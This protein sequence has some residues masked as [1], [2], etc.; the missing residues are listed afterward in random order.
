M[1]AAGVPGHAGHATGAWQAIEKA[2]APADAVKVGRI[3]DAWGVQGA[4]KVYPYSADPQALLSSRKWH[5]A[6]VDSPVQTFSAQGLVKVRDVKRQGS[7]VVAKIEGV[8]DRDMA[9]LYRGAEVSVARSSFPSTAKDEYYWVD[10]VGLNV[11]NLEGLVLGQVSD[12]MA[13]GPQTVLV[14]ISAAPD[15]KVLERLIPFV[16]HYVIDVDQ[17]QGWV[18]VDWQPDF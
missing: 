7:F 12:L 10:L 14:V 18:K 16:S 1:G 17:T 13:N 2:I 5:L 6:P 9:L 3:A 11:V 4:V 15:G 8:T